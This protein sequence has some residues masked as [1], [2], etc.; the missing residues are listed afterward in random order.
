MG[1]VV[2]FKKFEGVTESRL[3]VDCGV[4]TAPGILNRAETAAV[5]AAAWARAR[6]RALKCTSV[7]IPRSTLCGMPSGKRAGW[8]R[9]VAAC[10]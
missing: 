2:D 10:V 4:N 7:L 9:S 1:D 5:F 3:C 8:C 6:N